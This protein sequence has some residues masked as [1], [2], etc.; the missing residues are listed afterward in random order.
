MR[1]LIVNV[2][3]P[4]AVDA[5][6]HRWGQLSALWASRGHEV[7]VITGK[8]K[9]VEK[10][11]IVDGVSVVR[12]G[13]I[14]KI[15]LER[16]R[17]WVP[18]TWY[19]GMITVIAK[20]AIAWLKRIYRAFYWPDGWWHWFPFALVEVLQRRHREYDLIVSYSP[21][22]AGHLSVLTMR[23]MGNWTT[24]HWI[25]DYGDPFSISDT[26]PPNNFLL[27]R[28]LNRSIERRVLLTADSVAFNNVGTYQAYVNAFGDLP[29]AKVIPHLVDVEK[30][31][32]RQRSERVGVAPGSVKDK[33]SLVY[34]GGFHK[35]IREPGVLLDVFRRLQAS[36]QVEFTLSIF[37][38]TNG[39]DLE[40]CC[41]ET[42]IYRGVV[43][44]AEAI[45]IM[46]QADVLVNIENSNCVMTPSKVTE[47]IA[48]GRP[49]VSIRGN[50]QRSKGLAEYGALGF[51][52]DVS[53][54]I[55][56]EYL[57]ELARFIQNAPNNCASL[58]DVSSVLGENTIGHVSDAYIGLG[59]K[60]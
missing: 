29:S 5:H 4:P 12:V 24:A 7:E 43:A 11:S 32:V 22:F 14:S 36:G 37:G 34:I 18:A 23:L 48:T 21:S 49:I 30:F 56:E 25:A 38:P 35:G 40:S 50:G 45:S 31:H 15:L 3:Y 10:N 17:T 6:A 27:Y 9:G 26:M 39:V 19:F 51:V 53:G 60:G 47:Y 1:V 8:L 52:F 33:R 59:A 20:H 55:T 57:A 16:D 13:L 2:F 46:T 28:A 42:I 44:R 54:T 58:K 41:D